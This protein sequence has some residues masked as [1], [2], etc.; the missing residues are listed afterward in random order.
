MEPFYITVLCSLKPLYQSLF[1]PIAILFIA[2]H[3]LDDRDS[4]EEVIEGIRQDRIVIL[5]DDKNRESD[6]GLVMVGSAVT[7]NNIN[8]MTIPTTNLLYPTCWSYQR[9]SD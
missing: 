8:F 9:D 6:E 1:Q 5:V 7:P 3:T 4:S 2:H